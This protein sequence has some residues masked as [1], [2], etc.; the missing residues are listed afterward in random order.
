MALAGTSPDGRLV[1][2]IEL[3][4]HPFFLAAQF[5]RNFW[6]RPTGPTRCSGALWTRPSS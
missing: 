1:E 3:P 2:L 6:S 5:T 4:D